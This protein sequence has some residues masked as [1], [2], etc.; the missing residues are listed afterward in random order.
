M[1]KSPLGQMPIDESRVNVA[2]VYVVMRWHPSLRSLARN[3]TR[4]LTGN[5]LV[6]IAALLQTACWFAGHVMCFICDYC[7]TVLCLYKI[8]ETD[9][10]SCVCLEWK[11]KLH[12]AYSKLRLFLWSNNNKK[13]VSLIYC[14]KKILYLLIIIILY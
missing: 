4:F 6:D 5:I 10:V 8:I 3:P 7:L 2:T 11:L 12:Y 13:H 14:K 9:S 1:T